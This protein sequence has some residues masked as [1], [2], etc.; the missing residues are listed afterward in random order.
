MVGPSDNTMRSRH[1]QGGLST[2]RTVPPSDPKGRAAS[3]RTS[4]SKQVVVVCPPDKP[5]A[6]PSPGEAEGARE[7]LL[8]ATLP[9]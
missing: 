3:R 8:A 7:M 1:A 6:R 4:R 5:K 9:R 2:L